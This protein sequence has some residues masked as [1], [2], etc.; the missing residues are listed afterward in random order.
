[1]PNLTAA[2]LTTGGDT[3]AILQAPTAV[4][5]QPVSVKPI[6]FDPTP[7]KFGNYAGPRIH[8]LPAAEVENGSPSV[9]S[10]RQV[11]AAEPKTVM[12]RAN[13]TRRTEISPVVRKDYGVQCRTLHSIIRIMCFMTPKSNVLLRCKFQVTRRLVAVRL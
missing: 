5:V 8:E 1:M 7:I 9:S 6:S 12:A 3:T 10:D 11:S 2:A 13:R 4:T